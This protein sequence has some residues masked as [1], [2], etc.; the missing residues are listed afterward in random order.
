MPISNQNFGEEDSVT[1]CAP[2]YQFSNSKSKIR[3]PYDSCFWATFGKWVHASSWSLPY[4]QIF[5]GDREMS[6]NLDPM[7]KIKLIV[8]N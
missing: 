7:I 3:T 1:R 4:L 8:F 2:T 6:E 5:S